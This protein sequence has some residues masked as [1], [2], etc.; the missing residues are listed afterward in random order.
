VKLIAVRHAMPVVDPATPPESWT[1]SDDGLSAAAAM[2]LPSPAYLVAS[3]EPKAYQTLGSFGPVIRDARLGEIR[4]EGEPFH[5]NFRELRYEYV[6]GAD[7]PGWEPRA[8]AVARFDAAVAFHLAQAGDRPLV[9]ATHGMVLTLWLTARTGLAAP[10]EFW[11]ALRFPDALAVD[12]VA[13]TWR[14]LDT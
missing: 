4:R 10:G 9:L 13:S 14:R 12:L 2:R 11:S 6:S 1:L 5:G 3:E 7:H 8:D